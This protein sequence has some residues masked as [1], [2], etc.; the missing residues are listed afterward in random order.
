MKVNYGPL[1]FMAL[2]AFLVSG[3]SGSYFAGQSPYTDPQYVEAQELKLKVRELADQ[4]LAT[5]PNGYLNGYVA[6]PTSFVN[7]NNLQE[8]SPFGRLMGES[9][10]YEFNQ[11]GFLVREYRLPGYLAISTQKGTFALDRAGLI[12]ANERWTTLIVGTYYVDKNSVFVNVRLV[13]AI[14][15]MV[16]RTAQLVIANNEYVAKLFPNTRS[17][18]VSTLRIK[19]SKN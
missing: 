13:R 16:F 17:I 14:D 9:L 11:R 6:F 2:C 8:S 7:I 5:L 3:C 15:G 19:Q 18:A 10:I 12:M 4:L 1:L